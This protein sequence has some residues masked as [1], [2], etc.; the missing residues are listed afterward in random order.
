ML[1][2]GAYTRMKTALVVFQSDL[3]DERLAAPFD[4]SLFVPLVFFNGDLSGLIIFRQPIAHRANLRRIGDC[5]AV[6][7][8]GHPLDALDL[9]RRRRRPD[10]PE[11]FRALLTI[12]YKT[13]AVFGYG[14][15]LIVGQLRRTSVGRRRREEQ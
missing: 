15:L 8:I 2:I 13:V 6:C 3:M 11:F 5:A 14:D 7:R 9:R 10:Q 1:S 12:E 4:V